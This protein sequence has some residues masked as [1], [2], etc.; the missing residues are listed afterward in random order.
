MIHDILTL[1]FEF[2]SQDIGP[3]A[4]TPEILAAWVDGPAHVAVIYRSSFEPG[5][6]LGLRRFFGADSGMDARSGAAEI[7]ESVSEPLGDGVHFVRPDGE[8]V[9]WSGDL[10]DELPNAPRRR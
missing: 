2:V 7:Q 3:D 4:R 6:V 1:F 10:D 8:G 9:L 5:L